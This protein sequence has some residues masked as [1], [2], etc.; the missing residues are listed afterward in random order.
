M[1]IDCGLTSA[2]Y[3]TAYVDISALESG[4][5]VAH[6]LAVVSFSPSLSLV[7]LSSSSRPS[8]SAGAE[9]AHLGK[10]AEG[11]GVTAADRKQEDDDGGG[12]GTDGARWEEREVRGRRK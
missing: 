10:I 12:G 7:S 11:K 8:A 3:C 5:K 1:Q 2:I 4:V 6:Y 9:G